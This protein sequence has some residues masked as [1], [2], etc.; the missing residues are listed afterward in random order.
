MF[1]PTEFIYN[2]I[3]SNAAVAEVLREPAAYYD[4][5]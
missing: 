4:A 1:N 3:A 5:T 2:S